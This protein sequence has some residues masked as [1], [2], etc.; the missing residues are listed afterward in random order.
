MR[1]D[2]VACI[3][4]SGLH[5]G[6]CGGLVMV[7]VVEP[8]RPTYGKSPIVVGVSRSKSQEIDEA[9][10]EGVSS[11]MSRCL[12]NIWVSPGC[13]RGAFE[14]PSDHNTSETTQY[15][16][17]QLLFT[18]PNNSLRFII[19]TDQQ[20]L[21]D[22]HWIWLVGQVVCYDLTSVVSRADPLDVKRHPSWW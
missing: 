15:S 22:H 20:F 21:S 2:L 13:L 17:S 5:G 4:G 9:G 14:L 6:T 8:C 11:K 12:V 10:Y 18:T 1:L 16:G 19:N 7:T 3:S